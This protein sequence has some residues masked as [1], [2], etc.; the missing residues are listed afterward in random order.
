MPI[1]RINSERE[2]ATGRGVT[3]LPVPSRSMHRM[4]FAPRWIELPLEPEDRDQ[5]ILEHHLGDAG[6]ARPVGLGRA[7]SAVA[8]GC[9]DVVVVARVHRGT[10]CLAGARD[11][12][13]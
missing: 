2:S 4:L 7:R 11:V 3:S 9:D 6:L 12:E 10:P 5:A 1:Q 13:P 8:W